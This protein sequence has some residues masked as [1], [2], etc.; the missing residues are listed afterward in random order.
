[1][2]SPS[3]ESAFTAP[4]AAPFVLVGRI[5][6][7]IG[8]LLRNGHGSGMIRLAWNVSGWLKWRSK[9]VTS[10]LFTGSWTVN[11]G[12]PGGPIGLVFALPA[13]SCQVWKCIVSVGPILKRILKTSGS[14]TLWAN[15]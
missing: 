11:G 5:I 6:E 3:A 9:K 2:K 4:I 12:K 14:L 1:M 8:N 15:D 7:Q 13:L 10:E